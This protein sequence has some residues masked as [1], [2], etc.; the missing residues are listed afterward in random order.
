MYLSHL[1]INVG[2]NPD[3]PR[4]GRLW[5][6][7]IYHVH[8]R[9]CMAFP[10][11]P[12][13]ECDPDFLK[14]FDPGAFDRSRFL[15][16]VDGLVGRGGARAVILVQS[17]REPDWGYA[18]RNAEMLLAARPETREHAVDFEAGTVLRFRIRVNPTRKIGSSRD[19]TDVRKVKTGSDGR[20]R[21]QGKR[22][23]VVWKQEDGET[24]ENVVNEW[25]MGRAVRC[26]F[27]VGE[28]R[29]V[30]LGWV[31]GHKGAH[32]GGGGEHRIRLRSALLEGTLAVRDRELFREA[33]TSGIGS[34]K[35][36]GFG[37]LSVVAA[38]AGAVKGAG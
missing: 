2:E 14:P 29:L 18:F 25:F 1:L 8:Q 23:S 22:V 21:S 7:N 9:I 10:R 34:G 37:L 33:V 24:A 35:A 12:Q 28:S 32:G 11:G 4:P 20:E 16:R 17:D 13:K 30:S 15:Y 38:G 36:F 31:T 3:R 6:R 19:G 26:G 27:E 5:L